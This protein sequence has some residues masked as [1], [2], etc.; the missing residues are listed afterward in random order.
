MAIVNALWL[1]LITDM[2][3]SFEFSSMVYGPWSMDYHINPLHLVQFNTMNPEID[4]RLW[5]HFITPFDF[6][7]LPFYLLVIYFFMYRFCNRY[8]PKTLYRTHPWRKYF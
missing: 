1:I 8:Y 7:L 2:N 4:G 5:A 3:F 6:V